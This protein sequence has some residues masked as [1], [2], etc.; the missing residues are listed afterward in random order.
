VYIV[1]KR[2]LIQKMH[3][4]VQK[5]PKSA[6]SVHLK[7]AMSKQSLSGAHRAHCAHFLYFMC[8]LA[9]STLCTPCTPRAHCK[10]GIGVCTCSLCFPF[11]GPRWYRRG[12]RK[13][14]LASRRS[15]EQRRRKTAGNISDELRCCIWRRAENPAKMTHV[16]AAQQQWIHSSFA[17]EST[18]ITS[19]RIYCAAQSW[20]K[21]FA[22]SSTT[23]SLP[24]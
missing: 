2:V 5:W 20:A 19:T 1:S 6:Q 8:T 14:L 23:S 21:R 7:A 16:R 4:N 24:L 22:T 12:G 17:S 3:Q 10:N 9:M 18:C 15:D 13:L 11:P